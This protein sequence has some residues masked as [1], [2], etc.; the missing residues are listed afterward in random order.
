MARKLSPKRRGLLQLM[1]DLETQR[2]E[3]PVYFPGLSTLQ[4]ERYGLSGWDL[5]TVTWSAKAGLIELDPVHS[6]FG[7]LTDA[8]R[9]AI[10]DVTKNNDSF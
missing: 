9:K 4:L 6:G 8:G 7:K 3:L 10:N 1:L 2:P 5:A